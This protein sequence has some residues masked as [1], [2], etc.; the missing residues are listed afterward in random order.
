MLVYL[1]GPVDAVTEDTARNWRAEASDRLSRAGISTFSPAHAF[2]LGDSD[3][4][5][6]ERLIE[7]NERA[8]LSSH[9]VLAML[10]GGPSFGTPIECVTAWQAEIPVVAIGG[11]QRSVYRWRWMKTS[12][13]EEAVHRLINIQV[14]NAVQSPPIEIEVK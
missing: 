11:N 8:L 6:C 7:I 4:D 13:L 9:A 5:T 3:K 2:T 10:D 12:N 14:A 1:A